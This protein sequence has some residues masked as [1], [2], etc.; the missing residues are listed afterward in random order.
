MALLSSPLHVIAALL[1]EIGLHYTETKPPPPPI[2]QSITGYNPI[3]LPE[4]WVQPD[5]TE[6][7]MQM[8]SN[9][10]IS[11]KAKRN[12]RDSLHFPYTFYNKE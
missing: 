4:N 12:T 11:L 8:H 1:T 10:I 2:D 9:N 3:R 6:D 5:T 7:S